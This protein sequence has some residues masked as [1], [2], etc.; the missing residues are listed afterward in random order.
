MAGRRGPGV[1]TGHMARAER[2]LSSLARE[3]DVVWEVA[4]ARCPRASRNPR[5]ARICRDRPR[6]LVLTH[7]DLAEED[8]TGRWLAH[9]EG[10]V[11]AVAVSLRGVPWSGR[12]QLEAATARALARGGRQARPEGYRAVV[13]GMPNTGKSTLL[14]HML[15][16][17][18]ARVGARAGVTRGRQWFHLEG[19][20][21]LLDLPGVL[22]PRL[23]SWPATWRLWAVEVLPA[24]VADDEA[25]GAEL[26]AWLRLRTPRALEARYGIDEDGAGEALLQRVA[27]ARGLLA[28]GGLPHAAAAA[29]AVRR[30]FRQG[31]FGCVTLEDPPDPSA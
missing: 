23:G 10:E 16:E 5:L 22:A 26:V 9:L 28:P 25:A 27:L 11:T 7:V 13:A 1:L 19:G 24:G 3:V 14:N 30:D 29:Q 18:R 6:V 4:D 2:E 8:T 17:R 15:G 20:G 12:A 21:Q 31:L